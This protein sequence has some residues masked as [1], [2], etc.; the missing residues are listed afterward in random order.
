[1][2]R[3]SLKMFSG[4]VPKVA[5]HL[6]ADAQ[7]QATVNAKVDS[8]M[9]EAWFAN[10]VV[11][12]SNIASP[13]TLYKYIQD[14]GA[15]EDWYVSAEQL[16][17]VDNPQ[18]VDTYERVFF[19]GAVNDDFYT[20]E[21]AGMQALA[22]VADT[23]DPSTGIICLTADRTPG[24]FAVGDYVRD[25]DTLVEYKITDLDFSGGAGADT[26][27]IANGPDTLSTTIDIMEILYTAPNYGEKEVR[28]FANDIQAGSE[29]NGAVD[30]NI[31]GVNEPNGEISM[32][33]NT[34]GT[35]R[36]EGTNDYSYI[37]TYVNEYG[38]EGPPSDPTT[39]T[40]VNTD[41]DRVYVNFKPPF[42]IGTN[43]AGMPDDWHNQITGF[44]IYRTES[45]VTS[46][47]FL[48][49][50]EITVAAAETTIE[51]NAA[52]TSYTPASGTL[53]MT[54][55][56]ATFGPPVPT[57]ALWHYVKDRD[58]DRY[59]RIT[60]VTAG[61]AGVNTIVIADAKPNTMSSNI[62][63][64][65][66][67]T[68]DDTAIADLGSPIATE[69][70]YPPITGLDGLTSMA[71][72]HLY[73]WK[74]NV[75]YYSYPYLPHAW[76][77]TDVISIS[78][79]IVVARGFANTL[80][81]ATDGFPY[82][83]SGQSPRTFNKI[84][85]GEWLPCTSK[86]SSVLVNNAILYP[87]REGLIQLTAGGTMN[88]T[89]KNI[90]RETWVSYDLA[91]GFAMFRN[92]RYF[93]FPANAAKPGFILDY[94]DGTYLSLSNYAEC[95][96]ITPD[97]G[98]MYFVSVDASEGAAG[99][100]R[101]IK[102]WQGDPLNNFSYT[103]KSKKYIL[104]KN[105]NMGVARIE[106]DD[107]FY[108]DLL[109]R[110]EDNA[111]LEG[112]NAELFAQLYAVNLTDDSS[113]EG[114]VVNSY[115]DPTLT[116]QDAIA[117]GS[118]IPGSHRVQ[119]LVTGYSY[120]IA[121]V[122]L[123]N[124]AG[125][126]TITIDTVSGAGG[127]DSP[128]AGFASSASILIPKDLQGCINGGNVITREG[129]TEDRHTINGDILFDLNSISASPYVVMT[130]WA[131]GV[132]VFQKSVDTAKAF[133]LPRGFKGKR[134]EVQFSGTIPVRG[135]DMATTMKEMLG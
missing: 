91:N 31:L 112:L 86:R 72:G 71:S 56:M 40:S 118:I 5:S 78:Q 131:D 120:P 18:S 121:S 53:V 60:S 32:S 8:G 55:D 77:P 83:F 42:G 12:N 134:W 99:T 79:Q 92:N 122:S 27:T 38:E 1:M 52:V 44:K 104:P 100:R 73:A 11:E 115:A 48:F 3:I 41:T 133:K 7:A 95:G 106:L 67:Q 110:I 49:A 135:F 101:S 111:Y 81:I 13:L 35:N 21:V 98:V 2:S 128:P 74:N 130:I 29:W 58:N 62:D 47:D 23:Y 123:G 50:R 30:Y 15:T 114:I 76:K 125:S 25:T 124:G 16:D 107:D 17:F 39:P 14:D 37:Y 90:R 66:W 34:E 51:S 126:E 85:M 129:R 64:V 57:P 28:F 33:D 65:H 54:G 68:T 96:Y 59:Y 105:V 10:S 89:Q 20:D 61:G 109:Q 119:D 9:L 132:E 97:E 6:L 84:K 127:E 113:M 22:V 46:T 24:D 116:M 108:G 26:V 103:W 45:G 69:D 75:L 19:A 88:I 87:T 94:I 43:E 102:Q 36:G 80:C 63:I 70:Y 4:E 82:V 93:A 117:T